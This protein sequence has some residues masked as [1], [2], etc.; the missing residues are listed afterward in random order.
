MR[1]IGVI[2]VVAA[3]A[4]AG[5]GG[6]TEK[7]PATEAGSPAAEPDDRTAVYA[8]VVRQLVTKDNT[9]EDEESPFGRVFIDV[10][11]DATGDPYD[12]GAQ[13]PMGMRLSAEEQAAILRELADLPRVEFVEHPDSVVVDE[14][15][16]AQAIEGNGAL[17]TLGPISGDAER[18]TVPNDMFLGC[19]GGVWLTYVLERAEGG[20]RVTGTEGPIV[21]S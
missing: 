4:L 9:F 20:W 11:V 21:I 3:L 6:S 10:H 7:G 15:A 19:Q 1:R 17:I 16:C 13:K 2:L 5:C 12:P 14:G 18:V 8:A